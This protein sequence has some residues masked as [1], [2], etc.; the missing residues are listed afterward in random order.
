MIID[1]YLSVKDELNPNNREHA[2]ELFGYDFMID[3]DYRTWLIEVNTNPY[4]GIPN[5]FI[6]G[7]LPK[8]INE[9]FYITLDQ[10]YGPKKQPF[11]KDDTFEFELIYSD[12]NSLWSD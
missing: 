3:E 5:D 7:L 11:S 2:F 4:L 12:G 8:M 6:K 10:V 9:M 1:T